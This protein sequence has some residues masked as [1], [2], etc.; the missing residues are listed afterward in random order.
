LEA[1]AGRAWAA[2]LDRVLV[3]REAGVA[4]IERPVGGKR[5]AG[6]PRARRQYA[7]EHVDPAEHRLNE[8]VGLADA[9]QIARL[10][11]GQHGNREIEAAEH[12]LL[13]LADR[14]AAD[15]IA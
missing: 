6:A 9:H 15:R 3:L 1:G 2:A 8:V 13:P 4:D 12:R 14:K 7:I 5:L 10:I 11:R